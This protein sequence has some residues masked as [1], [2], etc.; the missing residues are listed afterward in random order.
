MLSLVTWMIHPF[1]VV[2]SLQHMLQLSCLSR[3]RDGKAFRLYCAAEKVINPQ[4]VLDV[5]SNICFYVLSVSLILSA[6]LNGAGC[7]LDDLSYLP[8]MY[9]LW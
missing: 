3:T 4:V 1:H 6:S 9:A 8:V 7:L 2:L 5:L